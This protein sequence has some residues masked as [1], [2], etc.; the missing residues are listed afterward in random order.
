MYLPSQHHSF[1]HFFRF[2]NPFI[3]QY[4][5][6]IPLFLQLR[7]PITVKNLDATVVLSFNE[8]LLHD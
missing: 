5:L 1:A 8:F 3:Q 6:I 4:E 7:Q 2:I